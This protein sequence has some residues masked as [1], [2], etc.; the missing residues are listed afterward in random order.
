MLKV[1]FFLKNILLKRMH[2][3]CIIVCVSDFSI[4]LNRIFIC[5]YAFDA[6][7]FHQ[8]RTQ[9]KGFRAGEMGR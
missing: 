2:G 5:L 3:W 4:Q 9:L 7:L 8:S 6:A 1:L